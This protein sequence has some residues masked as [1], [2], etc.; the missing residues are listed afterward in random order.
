MTER[1]RAGSPSSAG[2]LRPPRVLVADDEERLRKVV[3]RILGDRGIYADTAADGRQ[4]VAMTMSG[5]YD[6]VI[7]DLLMPGQDGFGALREIMRR[8]PDQP[9]LVLSCL[10]DPE[11]KMT[12]LGLGA[13]DY[14]P[15][16]FH[17]G[18]LAARVQARL[19]AAARPGTAMLTCG[20]LTLDVLRQQADAGAG[21]VPLSSRECQLLWVLM[22]RP[23]AAVSKEELL[24]RVWGTVPVPASNVL[25]V[26]VGRLRSRLGADVITTVRGEGYRAGPG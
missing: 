17:V 6:L 11:S 14:V 8:R 26:Y 12:S 10:T 16:P 2:S 18:E 21:P 3:V 7:L 13:D 4:A 5:S 15:K 25:D 1:S 20:R 19:R 9:V 23:G 22:H 24:A